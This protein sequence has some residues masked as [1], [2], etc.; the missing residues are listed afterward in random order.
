MSSLKLI[1]S[2]GEL[3]ASDKQVM[4]DG[5]L[6]YHA[7]QGHERITETFSIV[8]KDE[9]DTMLGCVIVGFLYHGMEIQT[10]WIDESIRNQGWGTK[11]MTAVE[12]EAIK[13][14]CTV[15]YTNTFTWQAPEFYKK[16][17]YAIYGQLDDFP[18]GN[19]LFYLSKRHG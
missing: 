7:S 12:A 2:N 18:V 6:A 11:L 3:S 14:G 10:L 4:I 5:M 15:S 16:L 13:R 1:P 8:L 9:N 17:G 19:T